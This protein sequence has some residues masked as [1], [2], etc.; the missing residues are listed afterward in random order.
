MWLESGAGRKILAG[1]EIADFVRVLDRLGDSWLD[2]IDNQVHVCAIWQFCSIV[3][4]A[5]TGGGRSNSFWRKVVYGKTTA[6]G[7]WG[8][9]FSI[10][11]VSPREEGGAVP[12]VFVGGVRGETEAITHKRELVVCR[13]RDELECEEFAAAVNSVFCPEG[14]GFPLGEFIIRAMALD[15]R[16]GRN[17]AIFRIVFEISKWD[18]DLGGA[19]LNR[20][21]LLIDDLVNRRL[22]PEIC[23]DLGLSSEERAEIRAMYRDSVGLANTRDG[24]RGSWGDSAP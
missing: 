17:N 21:K 5:V 24:E 3:F 16:A 12:L 9:D 8:H 22:L 11:Y 19:E 10:Q 15:L 6:N 23:E 13:L 2:F 14:E 18:K 7:C 4:V 20:M 1:K